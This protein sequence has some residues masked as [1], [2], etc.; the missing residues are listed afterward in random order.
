MRFR[1]HSSGSDLSCSEP[2]PVPLP[3]PDA[4]GG[5]SGR[6]SG[7]KQPGPRLP[8]TPP[9]HGP[10]PRCRPR[11]KPPRR[12]SPPCH[13]ERACESRGPLR[14]W[15]GRRCNDRA[16][17]AGGLFQRSDRVR[18][19]VSV[20]IS[21]RRHG[22]R[23]DRRP[24]TGHPDTVADQNATGHWIRRCT[25]L[26]SRS[27]LVA[28]PLR[29]AALRWRA[30]FSRSVDHGHRWA[31]RR[32]SWW[33]RRASPSRQSRG[34]PTRYCAHRNSNAI[35]TMPCTA[36]PPVRDFS[37]SAKATVG[38]RAR[39]LILVAEGR[40]AGAEAQPNATAGR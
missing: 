40:R 10:R 15:C 13:P 38:H 11:T 28:P 27:A 6:G 19:S 20:R 5:C 18:D 36:R 32:P 24:D 39:L 14:A 9:G 22:F 23:R 16:F 12:T 34:S 7:S 37:C 21:E 35:G 29:L 2:V 33:P 30:A 8:V 31:S 1:N 4:L 26:P 25:G 17:V 3:V